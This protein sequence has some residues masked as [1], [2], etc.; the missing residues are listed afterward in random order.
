MP[1]ELVT[2]TSRSVRLR[3][4]DA[5]GAVM[6]IVELAAIESRFQFPSPLVKLRGQMI[7]ANLGALERVVLEKLKRGEWT[8]GNGARSR[9]MVIGRPELERI[10]L[11][12]PEWECER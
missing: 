5:D 10:P 12:K 11:E 8:R 3:T 7:M 9:Q 6:V 1:L 4:A 2:S